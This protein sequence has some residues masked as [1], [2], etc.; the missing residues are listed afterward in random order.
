MVSALTVMVCGLTMGTEDYALRSPLVKG[1][2]VLGTGQKMGT[3]NKVCRRAFFGGN[4]G[5]DSTCSR[6][7]T[8]YADASWPGA[9]SLKTYLG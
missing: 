1:L 7:L 2:G 3:E 4:T 5:S 6:R 8:N 9:M